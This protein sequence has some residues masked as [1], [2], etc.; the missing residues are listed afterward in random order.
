MEIESYSDEMMEQALDGSEPLEHIKIDT[1]RKVIIIGNP[2][3][4]D[5]VAMTL[6]DLKTIPEE[7]VVIDDSKFNSSIF[8]TN[9]P[10]VDLINHLSNDIRDMSMLN[11][12]FEPL[13]K[14]Q[15]KEVCVPVRDSK[16]DPKVDRNAPCTCGSGLKYK[17]CCMIKT[18]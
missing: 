17:K 6:A 18:E 4:K 12:F 13:T 15:A 5:E 10:Y 8:L 2:D 3:I 1:G 7:V 14:K 16:A 11:P 9:D